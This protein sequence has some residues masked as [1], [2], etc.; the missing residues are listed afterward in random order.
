M[1]RLILIRANEAADLSNGVADNMV[2]RYLKA[3]TFSIDKS[4]VIQT[5]K[6]VNTKMDVLYTEGAVCVLGLWYFRFIVRLTNLR[7]EYTEIVA[8]LL[9]TRGTLIIFG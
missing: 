3:R 1:F 7:S 5:T 2:L 8:G 6:F 9:Y 4:L